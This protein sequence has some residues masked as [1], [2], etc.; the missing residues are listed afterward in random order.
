MSTRS[1]GSRSW[2]SPKMPIDDAKTSRLAVGDA[3][4]C[5]IRLR[6]ASTFTFRATSGARSV[7]GGMMAARWITASTPSSACRSDPGSVMSPHTNCTR[8][9]KPDASWRA[10]RDSRSKATTSW[11]STSNASNVEKPMLPIAPVNNTFNVSSSH[12]FRRGEFPQ[13]RQKQL[14]HLRAQVGQGRGAGMAGGAED[15]FERIGGSGGADGKAQAGNAIRAELFEGL[16]GVGFRV[17]A[18]VAIVVRE[19][20]RKDDQQPVRCA[21]LGLE[22]FAR[23]ADARR[24]GACSS[25]V[26]VD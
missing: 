21:G 17:T 23:A 3:S 22:N 1:G 7:E 25:T 15:A 4:I 18:F 26:G 5:A 16:V 12:W 8:P 10:L 11:P 14:V 24:R 13:G 2:T 19:T 9:S 20:I 6:V